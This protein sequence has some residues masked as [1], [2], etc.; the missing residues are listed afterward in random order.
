LI[1]NN[2]NQGVASLKAQTKGLLTMI[3]IIISSMLILF[4]CVQSEETVLTTSDTNNSNIGAS[5]PEETAH[6]TAEDTTVV[7]STNTITTDH[8]GETH[9]N[10]ESDIN[11]ETDIIEE[12][13]ENDEISSNKVAAEQSEFE[14]VLTPEIT[15]QTHVTL[16]IQ[17][18]DDQM[19]ILAPMEL[20]WSEGDSVMDILRF[21]TREKGIVLD[22]RGMGMFTYV[23]GIA[24]LY[25]FDHGPE[26]GWLY[27]IN[28]EWAD[29]SA[30]S[31][32]VNEGDTI[33]WIYTTKSN[34]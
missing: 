7:E 5:H 4:S 18:N 28:G 11:G 19:M 29:K 20:K 9:I 16:S 12:S 23:E 3:I 14:E 31:I 10:D 27:K 22:T 34:N 15:K 26:S 17:G 32:K 8:E 6:T 25:E 24:N 2:L 1:K 13:V 33:E 21:A 30:A